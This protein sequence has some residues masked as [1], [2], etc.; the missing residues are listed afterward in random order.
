MDIFDEYFK[1]LIF[2]HVDVKEGFAVYAARID[3]GLCAQSRYVLL[4]VEERFAFKRQ[5]RIRELKWKNLQTRTLQNSYN[6]KKQ[7][8]RAPRSIPD[9]MLKVKERTNGYTSY[10][11]AEGPFPVEILLLHSPKK[12]TKYQ[13]PNSMLFSSSIELFN[14]VFNFL[15]QEEVYDEYLPASSNGNF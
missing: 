2:T 7:G 9:F 11:S 8:W 6:I 5:A 14:G 13:H 12:K 4:F 1:T 15:E 10:V 3:T